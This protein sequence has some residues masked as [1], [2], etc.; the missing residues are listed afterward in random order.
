MSGDLVAQEKPDIG[1][2]EGRAFQAAGRARGKALRWKSAQ[3]TETERKPDGSE[4][5]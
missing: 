4:M 3:G 2:A 1:R 5:R